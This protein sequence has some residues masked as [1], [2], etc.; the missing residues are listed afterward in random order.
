MEEWTKLLET[1]LQD[2]L[3]SVANKCSIEHVSKREWNER[4]RAS[5]SILPFPTKSVRDETLKQIKTNNIFLSEGSN[6]LRFDFAKTKRQLHRN[7]CVHKAVE[8]LK[9]DE[10]GKDKLVEPEWKHSGSIQTAFSQHS[11]SIQ[12][13]FRQHSDSI[14]AT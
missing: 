8:M 9:R 11:D 7:A 5:V 2:K 3:A 14:R 13:L 6:S 12:M 4:T 1:F 10:Q